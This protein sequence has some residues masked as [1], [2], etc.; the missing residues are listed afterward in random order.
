MDRLYFSFIRDHLGYR[1]VIR[2]T[3]LSETVKPEKQ[4]RCQ[5]SIE[6]TGFAN[7][8]HP[9]KAE[10]LLEKNG[11]YIQTEVNLDPT[12]WYSCTTTEIPLT[13]QL[14]GDLEAGE[15]RVYL[16]LSIGNQGIAD[17]AM[18]TV[19]FANANIWNACWE[20]IRLVR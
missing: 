18:R 1:F 16:R 13:L 15:W 2:D 10:I 5:L 6:N 7:P 12:Q 17:S 20:Q 4:L 14:P 3:K 11:N 9:L 8:I 19:R